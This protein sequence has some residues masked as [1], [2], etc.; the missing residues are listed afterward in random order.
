MVNFI[1]EW[2]RTNLF[3]PKFANVSTQLNGFNYCNLTLIF[4]FDINYLLAHS[5]VVSGITI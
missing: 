5:E 2:V 4:L 1:F 3:A